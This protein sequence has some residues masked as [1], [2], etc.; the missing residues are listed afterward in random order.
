MEYLI[1]LDFILETLLILFDFAGLGLLH[2]DGLVLLLIET[3]LDGLG[4]DQTHL[5]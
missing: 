1:S 2:L 4:L 5:P 3:L